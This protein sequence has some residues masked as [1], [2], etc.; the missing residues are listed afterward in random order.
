MRTSGLKELLSEIWA[1]RRED[2]GRGGRA[3]IR[4]SERLLVKSKEVALISVP[5]LDSVA[6][7]SDDVVTLG[8][9]AV[10]AA[11]PSVVAL[12]STFI[13]ELVDVTAGGKGHQ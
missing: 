1:W 5:R 2:D 10:V 9:S 6:G 4:M 12:V 7:A 3:D 13:S 11:R 8:E